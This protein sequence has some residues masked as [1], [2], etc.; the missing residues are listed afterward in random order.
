MWVQTL[1]ISGVN[2]CPGIRSWE[3]NFAQAFS[4]FEKKCVI[5]DRRVRKVI[6]LLKN[7][8]FGTLKVI[9][10]CLVIRFLAVICPGIRFFWEILPGLGF[11]LATHPYLLLLGSRRAWQIRN[12]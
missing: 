1:G 11:A 4:N 5:F 12:R 7:F 3:V 9:K 10:T 2:L 6:Y 8:N